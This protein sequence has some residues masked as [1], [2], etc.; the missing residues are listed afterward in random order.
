[1]HG[2]YGYEEARELYAPYDQLVDPDLEI[3]AALAKVIHSTTAAGHKGYVTISNK[4][5]GSAPLTVE[6]LARAV[7]EVPR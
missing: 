3:R 4:A 6:A 1:M 2:A 7:L 5:E